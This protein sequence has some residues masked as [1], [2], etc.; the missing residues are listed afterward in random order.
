MHEKSILSCIIITKI[1]ETQVYQI[2]NIDTLNIF[3]YVK[4]TITETK[5]QHLSR[6]KSVKVR[7]I[8]YPSGTIIMYPHL[9]LCG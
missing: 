2:P 4:V 7:V 1:T 8:L 3:Y 5:S 9:L 6:S